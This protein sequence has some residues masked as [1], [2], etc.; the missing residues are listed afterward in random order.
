MANNFIVKTHLPYDEQEK[1][2]QEEARQLATLSY[3]KRFKV[4]LSRPLE[5]FKGTPIYNMA[6]EAFD[7]NIDGKTNMDELRIMQLFKQIV[8]PS[9]AVALNAIKL[10]YQL[11]GTFN[12][13]EQ[14]IDL[15]EIDDATEGVR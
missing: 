3:G 10:S 14:N 9:P 11:D 7:G 1:I 12:E 5:D 6:M 8:G 4:W 2:Y 13:K 15:D